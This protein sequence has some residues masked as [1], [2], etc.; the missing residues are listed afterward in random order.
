MKGQGNKQEVVNAVVQDVIHEMGRK[1][2]I[3]VLLQTAH[4][5]AEISLADPE[6]RAKERQ[7]KQWVKAVRAV[8]KRPQPV[9]QRIGPADAIRAQG[10]ERALA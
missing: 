1:A 10:M 7:Y 4:T 3:P 2:A 8:C 5:M 9:E 6:N